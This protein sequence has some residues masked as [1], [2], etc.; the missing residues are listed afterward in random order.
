MSMC[1]MKT[2]RGLSAKWVFAIQI[3]LLIV[4]GVQCNE[5]CETHATII[6]RIKNEGF[7]R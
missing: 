3:A 5:V 1:E 2:K 7:H 6:R 4:C